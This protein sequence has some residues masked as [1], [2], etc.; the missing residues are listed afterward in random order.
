MELS[1]QRNILP[2]LGLAFCFCL[3][4]ILLAENFEGFIPDKWFYPWQ[5]FLY[6][7]ATGFV[8]IVVCVWWLT[9][10]I[11][12]AQAKF[13]AVITLGIGAIGFA[14]DFVPFE[15]SMVSLACGVLL[16]GIGL[17]MIWAEKQNI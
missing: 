1:K 10:F 11:R 7:P 14:V 8:L 2:N 4:T 13:C 9:K 16:V 5:E 3:L 6:I 12:F 15:P 17:L